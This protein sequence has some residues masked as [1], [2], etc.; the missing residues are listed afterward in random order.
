MVYR[1][2]HEFKRFLYGDINTD[3]GL[4]PDDLKTE[5]VLDCGAFVSGEEFKEVVT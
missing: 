2:T 3:L 1:F 4:L 5:L